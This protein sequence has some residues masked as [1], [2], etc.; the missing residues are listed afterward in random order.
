MYACY[1]KI[2]FPKNVTGFEA[3]QKL[4]PTPPTHIPQAKPYLQL[5]ALF[6]VLEVAKRPSA[7]LTH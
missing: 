7:S 5:L 6:P 1:E 3:V 2:G 4:P